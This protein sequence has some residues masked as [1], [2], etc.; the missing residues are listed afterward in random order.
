MD[1]RSGSKNT[2]SMS[3]GGS[4][5]ASGTNLRASSKWGNAGGHRRNSRASRT[6]RDNVFGR[7][8][9]TT[10]GPSSGLR[11]ELDH[12]EDPRDLSRRKALRISWL[13][14]QRLVKSRP[15]IAV[16]SVLAGA[17]IMALLV[18]LVLLFASN[19]ISQRQAD[20][21][22]AAELL[23]SSIVDHIGQLR[24]PVETLESLVTVQP[25]W[26]LLDETFERDASAILETV[27]RDRDR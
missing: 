10:S 9:N 21:E 2:I 19:V 18:S 17:V 6:S 26:T 12:D 24:G 7:S 22:T 4:V 11:L 1:A 23:R 15:S 20:L 27:N 16:F 13:N 3:E 8:G 25:N 14:A 5:T